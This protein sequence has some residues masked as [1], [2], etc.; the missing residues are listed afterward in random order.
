VPVGG[1]KGGVESESPGRQAR[2]RGRGRV[3][4]EG[5]D[6]R[7]THPGGEPRVAPVGGGADQRQGE[8]G[9]GG[10]GQPGRDGGRDP[11]PARGGDTVEGRQQPA[12]GLVGG[13]RRAGRSVP[14]ISR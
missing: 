11:E 13:G 7:V 3:G 10:Q 4:G 8:T 12:A 9:D 14:Y 5:V 2:V 6:D 1:G